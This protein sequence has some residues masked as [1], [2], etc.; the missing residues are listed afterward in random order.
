M[1]IILYLLLILGFSALLLTGCEKSGNEQKISSD[2][3]EVTKVSDGDTFEVLRYGRKEKIRLIGVDTPEK[4]L[5]EK[6]YKLS[7]KYDINVDSLVR[8]GTN[9]SNFLK[10]TLLPGTKVRLEF[11]RDS[12]DQYKRTLAYA[13]L[14]DGRMLNRL[15]AESGYCFAVFYKPNEKYR[16]ELEAAV[17]N[18]KEK[19]LGIWSVKDG[20]KKKM[21]F[22]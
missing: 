6:N 12:T 14:E 5:N 3:V 2:Y 17:E 13:Y 21:K 20:F 19:G 11:D 10:Q 18:A 8:W 9:A 4:R 1:K 15:I 7:K 22:E 16:P